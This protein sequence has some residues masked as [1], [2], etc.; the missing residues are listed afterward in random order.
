MNAFG[1]TTEDDLFASLEQAAAEQ[2]RKLMSCIVKV[3]IGVNDKLA[4]LLI[5]WTIEFRP[6]S[7]LNSLLEPGS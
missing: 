7:G 2:G 1:T 3:K 4:W 6:Q 5:S